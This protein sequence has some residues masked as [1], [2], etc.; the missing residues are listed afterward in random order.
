MADLPLSKLVVG[1]P[2]ASF[3]PRPAPAAVSVD[4][5]T[6]GLR[7]LKRYMS[8]L[9]FYR[10]GDKDPVTGELGEPILFKIPPAD[11]HIGWPDGEVELRRPS[12]V[13]MTLQNPET[14]PPGMGPQVMEETCDQFGFGTVLQRVGYRTERFAIEIHASSK[15]ESRSIISCIAYALNPTQENRGVRFLLPDYYEQVVEFWQESDRQRDEES[16]IRNRREAS[17]EVTM[18]Q[19]LVVLIPYVPFEAQIV[20]GVDDP[21]SATEVADGILVL[22]GSPRNLRNVPLR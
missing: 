6:R 4:V 19:T 8:L 5:R 11:I 17:V 15:A 20:V 7:V 21:P 2:Y 18:S 1:T 10:P 16:A 9:N 13:F 22:D 3:P 14:E 12:L